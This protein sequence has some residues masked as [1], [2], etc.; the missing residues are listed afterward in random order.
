MPAQLIGIE[1]LNIDLWPIDMIS[2]I[3]GFGV[4]HQSDMFVVVKGHIQWH[5][6][7]KKNV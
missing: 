7:I 6:R 3:L 4:Y 1:W 5:V 2:S